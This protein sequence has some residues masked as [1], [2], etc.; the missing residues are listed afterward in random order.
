MEKHYIKSKGIWAGALMMLHGIVLALLAG[1]PTP[2]AI[3]A[4][5]TGLGIVG[6]RDAV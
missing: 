4:F 6:I 2:E 1:Q 5:L 3:N